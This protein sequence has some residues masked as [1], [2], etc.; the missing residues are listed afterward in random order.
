VPDQQPPAL[1]LRGRK[2]TVVAG[3]S[4]AFGVLPTADG[5]KAVW[6]VLDAPRPRLSNNPHVSARERQEA[7]ILADAHGMAIPP[8]ND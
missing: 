7:L 1:D 8:F 6:A 2:L 5:G 3:L 4:R